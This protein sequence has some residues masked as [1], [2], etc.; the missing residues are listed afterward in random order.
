MKKGR[1]LGKQPIEYTSE[2]KPEIVTSTGRLVTCRCL[3]PVT[4]LLA[5]LHLLRL[6]HRPVRSDH[7]D[8]LPDRMM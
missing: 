5:R 2:T 8:R 1:G 6:V 7:R 4:P 3:L